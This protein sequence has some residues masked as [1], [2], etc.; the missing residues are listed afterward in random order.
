VITSRR[1]LTDTDY[2]FPNCLDSISQLIRVT[3]LTMR[4]RRS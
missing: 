1:H 2:V 4:S 3:L